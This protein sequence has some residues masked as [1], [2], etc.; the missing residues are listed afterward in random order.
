MEKKIKRGI[1]FTCTV[2]INC[3]F[4]FN[5]STCYISLE[6]DFIAEYSAI[7]LIKLLPLNR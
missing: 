6:R 7:N 2:H 5:I 4:F 1:F 3:F